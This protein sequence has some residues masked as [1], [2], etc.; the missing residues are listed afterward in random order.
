MPWTALALLL[1]RHHAEN[2][3]ELLLLQRLKGP[4]EKPVPEHWNERGVGHPRR[5][6]ARISKHAEVT[7]DKEDDLSEA[8]ESLKAKIPKNPKRRIPNGESRPD[9]DA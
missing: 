7:A 1:S 5:N 4:K 3:V 2:V 9:A 8:E 6:P